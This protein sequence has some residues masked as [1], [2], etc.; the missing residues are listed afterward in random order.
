[1]WQLILGPILGTFGG[2]LNRWLDLK[3]EKQKAEERK[4]ERA[5][6]LLVMDKEYA[7]AERKATL[8]ASMRQDEIAAESF[9]DSYK[10]ANERLLPEGTKLTPGQKWLAL[11]ID[12]F[13]RLIRPAATVW[14]QFALTGVFVWAAMELKRRGL[15]ALTSEQFGAL[16]AEIIYSIVGLAE[17]TLLWWFGIRG[18][19][20]KNQK[21]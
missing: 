13:T 20:K 10:F 5:H 16:T 11:A 14:Y 18:P 21:A 4:E 9:S 8:E 15:S 6:E 12:A 2:L 1:M 17:T 7:L 3:G 19:S